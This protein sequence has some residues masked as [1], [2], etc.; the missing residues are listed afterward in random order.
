MSHSKE[1]DTTNSESEKEKNT[2]TKTLALGTDGLSS[3]HE[4][5]TTQQR[6]TSDTARGSESFN[7]QTGKCLSH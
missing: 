2:D 1:S 6:D 7:Q 4:T 3:T 5:D